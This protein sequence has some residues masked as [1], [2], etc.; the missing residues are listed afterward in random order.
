MMDRR[1]SGG[2][3]LAIFGIIMWAFFGFWY[4]TI[5][6]G[7]ADGFVASSAWGPNISPHGFAGI[8]LI[9]G[10]VLTAIGVGVA[11]SGVRKANA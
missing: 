6:Q 8:S 5:R 1:V 9:V 3:G 2:A 7:T 10:I 11:V 4:V